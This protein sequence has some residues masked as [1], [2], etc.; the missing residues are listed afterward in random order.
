MTIGS[1]GEGEGKRETV[2]KTWEEVKSMLEA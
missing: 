1:C 2:E